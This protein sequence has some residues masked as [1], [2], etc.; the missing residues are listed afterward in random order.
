MTKGHKIRIGLFVVM[1]GVLLAIVLFVFG[2]LRFWESR[3]K[4]TVRFDGSV[5]GLQHGAQV[6]L[7]GLRV[8]AVEDL[9]VARDDL[10]KVDVTISLKSG[11]PVRADT[12]ARLQM[13]GITGLKVID[14]RDGTLAAA[15]LLPGS[16]ILQGDTLLDKLQDQAKT[17]VDQS[18]QLVARANTVID[19]LVV[20]TDP[21][22]FAAMST[23]M[24]QAKVTSGNL[25]AATAG[26]KTMI[27]E[28]GIALRETI[29]ATGQTAKTAQV[30]IDGQVSLLLTN[31]NDLVS[32]MKGLVHDNGGALR[33]AVFDLRQASR[34]F[35]ELSR[36]VRQRPS[37]LFFGDSPRER[38]L[39]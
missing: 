38:K 5:M 24:E 20:V 36:E 14:L 26:L 31:A 21:K 16:V 37:R 39:P 6:Y 9:D 22:Q 11:T 3:D 27:T 7:N 30:V 34:S 15:P 13:A 2:G 10:N 32:Q 18:I 8:G 29:V 25:A 28:N 33:S 1:T 23:I 17:L 19:N 35:K 12:R 4:Y